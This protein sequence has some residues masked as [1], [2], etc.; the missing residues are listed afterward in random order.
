MT[1]PFNYNLHENDNF[2]KSVF[3]NHDK[4]SPF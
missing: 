3:G 4:I 1:K 2:L